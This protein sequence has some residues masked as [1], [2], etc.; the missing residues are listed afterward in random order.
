[1]PAT[2]S[3]VGRAP[4]DA[5]VQLPHERLRRAR[6]ARAE[7]LGAIARR[8]GVREP[9]LRAIED[10]RFADLPHGVYARAAIK[11]YAAGL[12]LPPGE[13]LAACEPM[14]PAVDDPIAALC[15]LRGIRS[16]PVRRPAANVPA[17]TLFECPAWQLA[18]V[19]ALDALVVV[20]MLLVVVVCTVT[21]SAVPIS[22]LGRAAAPGFGAMALVLWVCYM[23]LFGGIAGATIGERVVGL[24]PRPRDV[25]PADLRL[26]AAR[27]FHCACRDASFIELLGGWLGAVINGS[28]TLRS[29]EPIL[30]ETDTRP[31]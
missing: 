2:G 29:G 18:A 20:A 10:G 3:T 11:S 28:G 17:A 26:V 25:G 30:R 19:A 14:L 1:V 13:I 24:E 7:G 23:V 8:I 27:A 15:R 5:P 6:I 9:L 12:D 4:D 21:A 22:S 16:S 31:C